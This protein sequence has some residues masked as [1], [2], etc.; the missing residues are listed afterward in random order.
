[1]PLPRHGRLYENRRD[2]TKAARKSPAR[3]QDQARALPP[4]L[5]LP[6]L[7]P[8]P[9]HRRTVQL[10]LTAPPACVYARH[11]QKQ[12]HSCQAQTV[13]CATR[14]LWRD[15]PA[16][17]QPPRLSKVLNG[18]FPPHSERRRHHYQRGGL[19][20]RA[21]ADPA[22][23]YRGYPSYRER[24]VMRRWHPLPFERLGPQA[25]RPM[26]LC[27]AI[28]RPHSRCGGLFYDR[29]LQPQSYRVKRQDGPYAAALHANRSIQDLEGER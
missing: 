20:H 12:H 5:P 17:L 24:R 28:A 27:R 11:V 1:M 22:I 25:T 2:A 23:W 9:R 26:A 8:V 13:P 19:Q 29:P 21:H 15:I 14:P 3:E 16:R 7:P 10:P 18:S 4:R 6:M